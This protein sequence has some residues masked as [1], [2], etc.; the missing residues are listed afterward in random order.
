MSG[1]L[2][3]ASYVQR[4]FGE[5]LSRVETSAD[6]NQRRGFCG[7]DG[8]SWTRMPISFDSWSRHVGYRPSDLRILG[9]ILA[10]DI[11]VPVG[12]LGS[13]ILSIQGSACRRSRSHPGRDVA[14]SV[15]G[16]RFAGNPR[17]SPQPECPRRKTSVRTREKR[18]PR[19]SIG[20]DPSLVSPQRFNAPP[21]V[22]ARH[23]RR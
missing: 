3:G 6:E 22:L 1:L 18:G 16:K 15:R 13:V 21:Q 12:P 7:G 11:R 5:D 8:D 23:P 17:V 20:L 14:T 19:F 2:H 9:M 4:H 10:R